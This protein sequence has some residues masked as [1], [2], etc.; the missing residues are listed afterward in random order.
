MI[1]GIDALF[2][3]LQEVTEGWVCPVR[4]RVSIQFVVDEEG[5]VPEARVLEGIHEECDQMAIKAIKHMAFSPPTI[6]GE[7]TPILLSIPVTFD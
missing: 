7:P 4:G 2:A 3:V 1:G 6:G 5:S